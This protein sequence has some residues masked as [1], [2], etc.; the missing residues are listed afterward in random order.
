MHKLTLLLPLFALGCATAGKQAAPTGEQTQA[1]AS[2]KIT[3]SQAFAT[4]EPKNGSRVSGT[5]DFE[6]TSTGLKVG[7]SITGLKPNQ[8]HGFHVHEHGDCSSPDGKSAGTHYAP[9]APTGG[10]SLDTPQLYAGDLP[11][12]KSDASGR[13]MGT[14]EVAK[15]SI[16]GQFGVKDRA[17]MVHGGP[18]DPK[19]KS[20]PRVG[21][22]VIKLTQ[23]AM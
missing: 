14:F 2:P 3:Q 16:N 8:E 18:D 17:I 6:E 20:A 21:C 23:S 1:G 10:T 5:V 15:L 19:K 9:I 22:G 7:Y 4:L 13:A 12:V 11:M